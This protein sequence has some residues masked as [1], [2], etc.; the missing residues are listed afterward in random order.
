ME[1]NLI[2]AEGVLNRRL[3][4]RKLPDMLCW[5]DKER[6]LGVGAPGVVGPLLTYRLL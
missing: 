6:E 2:V 1:D 3:G 5:R 4:G